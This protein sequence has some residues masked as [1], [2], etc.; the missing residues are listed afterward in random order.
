M[1]RKAV[2]VGLVAA[3]A[4]ASFFGSRALSEKL[5]PPPGGCSLDC[6]G[7]QLALTSRQRRQCAASD[8]VFEQRRSALT[9]TLAERQAKLMEV[10]RKPDPGRAEV[11]RALDAVSEIQAALQRAV[12][13]H[14]LALKS[15]LTADQQKA[16][17]DSLGRHLCGCAGPGMGAAGCQP[18]GAASHEEGQCPMSG[19]SG[20]A[21]GS[22]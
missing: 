13:D 12:V 3:C 19:R 5:A 1:K 2:L 4:A 17:F 20:R 11:D 15:V 18:E 21:E 10:L 7:P 22:Q 8:K 16:L 9:V 14:L 6:F